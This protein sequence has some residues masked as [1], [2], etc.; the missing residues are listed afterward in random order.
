MVKDRMPADFI[1]RNGQ[2]LTVDANDSIS[3]AIAVCG[4]N[5]QAVGSDADVLALAGPDTITID[6]RGRTVIPGIVDIHAHMDREGL[7]VLHPSPE[8]FRSIPGIL[9]IVRG[10]VATKRPGEWVVTMPIG[11]P[12]NY[13]DLPDSLEEGRYHTRLELDRVSPHNPVY[14]RGIWTPW[15]VPPSVSVANS[16]AMKKAGIDRNTPVPDPSVTIETDSSGEPNGI[17]ID[18]NRFPTVEFTLMRVVPR[19]THGQRVQALKDS[20]RLYNSVGTTG[21]YE[22]HG[23]AHEVLRAYKEVWDLGNITVPLAWC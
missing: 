9:D 1:L 2:I 21:T 10:E 6:L 17:F 22:G 4:E 11:D 18:R 14:I 5:I 13:A 15:D 16:L 8:G 3:Q 23:V 12:P 19:F 20:M 7:K